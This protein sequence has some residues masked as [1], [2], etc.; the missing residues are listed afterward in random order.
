[1]TIN[2]HKKLFKLDEGY[3]IK[4]SDYVS[5]TPSNVTSYPFGR[6]FSYITADNAKHYL[7]SCV[8][9]FDIQGEPYTGSYHR[10]K[11]VTHLA[12]FLTNNIANDGS[13]FTQNVKMSMYL[14]IDE[15][16][17]TISRVYGKNAMF[18]MLKSRGQYKNRTAHMRY[19]P[20]TMYYSML[21][22]I[23]LWYRTDRKLYDALDYTV[24]PFSELQKTFPCFWFPTKYTRFD[25]FMREGSQ[26]ERA[27]GRTFM[28]TT[29]EIVSAHSVPVVTANTGVTRNITVAS[30]NKDMDSISVTNI[31]KVSQKTLFD[32]TS[33]IVIYPIEYND[34]V[35]NRI[36]Y[37]FYIRP[38]FLDSFY[39]EYVDT[40]KYDICVISQ[41][42]SKSMR[43]KVLDIT[44]PGL[45]NSIVFNSFGPFRLRDLLPDGFNSSVLGSIASYQMPS[46][47]ILLREKATGRFSGMSKPSISFSVSRDS[48]K[49]FNVVVQ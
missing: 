38:L 24:L 39:F 12:T 28:S 23:C 16:I 3:V 25:G 7:E 13:Q 10:F 34:A 47:K 8:F 35:N 41:G 11:N 14:D 36:L 20:S 15:D 48:L 2:N 17:P 44:T 31:K 26:I 6:S 18:A 49:K 30:L 32:V 4:T 33:S 9:K 21:R 5:I 1:M 22:D 42:A 40:A 19:V 43:L 46:L 27:G 29:G 37:A 45:T